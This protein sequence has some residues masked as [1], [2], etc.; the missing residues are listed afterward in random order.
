MSVVKVS[1]LYGTKHGVATTWLDALAQPLLQGDKAGAAVKVPIYMRDGG[2]FKPPSST[3]APWIMIGPG[4]GELRYLL[5]CLRACALYLLW[6][7]ACGA[8]EA[9]MC[10]M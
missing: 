7:A 5:R 9:C 10:C 4:T 6:C 1:T 8:C 3:Q 2:A